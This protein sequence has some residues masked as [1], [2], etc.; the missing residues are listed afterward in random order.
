MR[1]VGEAWKAYARNFERSAFRLEVQPTY[2]MPAEQDSVRR[3]LAGES[4]PEGHNAEWHATVRANIAAGKIM[5][6]VRVVHRPLTDY[7]RY[8][9]AWSVPGNVAAGEDIRVLD[10]TGKPWPPLPTFDF[11]LYDEKTVARLDYHMDGTQIGRE[12][13]EDAD[14]T[15]YFEW[16]DYALKHSVPFLEYSN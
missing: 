9:F 4:V 10:L 14:L 16:R 5:Q 1:L 6:R 8:G 3:F 15:Q 2:T 7:Q 11:W 12:L 13:V